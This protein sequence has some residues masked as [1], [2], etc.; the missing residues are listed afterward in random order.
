MA[1]S[2]LHERATLDLAAEQRSREAETNHKHLSSLESS[3]T[4]SHRNLHSDRR[5]NPHPLG[6]IHSP[7]LLAIPALGFPAPYVAPA[8]GRRYSL[9]QV[10]SAG[11][12]ASW[13]RNSSFVAGSLVPFRHPNAATSTC[14]RKF[15]TKTI[16]R[17]APRLC[18]SNRSGDPSLRRHWISCK[19]PQL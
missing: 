11:Q 17:C 2:R 18:R 16:D 8:A 7:N 13:H 6:L 9:L 4:G 3:T 19:F 1:V 10:V 5:N 15:G 14:A 12:H